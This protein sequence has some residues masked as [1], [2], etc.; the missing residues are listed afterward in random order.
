MTINF[1]LF[2]S[3][4]NLRAHSGASGSQI[5]SFLQRTLQ[6]EYDGKEI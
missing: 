1:L 4:A 6:G 5:S 3:L 2:I